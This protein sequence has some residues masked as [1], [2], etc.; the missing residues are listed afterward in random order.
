MDIMPD[1]SLAANFVE[2]NPVD[3]GIQC[4]QEM[5]EHEINTER[6]ETEPRGLNH[7]EGGWPKDVNPGEVEQTIRYRKKVEKDEMY[8][9]TIVQ[10]GS[11]MEHCIKQ[12]NAIGEWMLKAENSPNIIMIYRHINEFST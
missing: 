6:Y 10:L 1:D 7:I 2:K 8:V 3:I 12:N 4:V 5:S 9:N 11:V